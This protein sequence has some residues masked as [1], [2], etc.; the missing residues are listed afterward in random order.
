[1]YKS[2]PVLQA[3]EGTVDAA[4]GR[5][6]GKHSLLNQNYEIIKTKV[7]GNHRLA[8]VHEFNIQEGSNSVLIETPL[9]VPADLS[10]HGGGKG[11]Q[12]IVNNGFQGA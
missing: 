9:A 12:W 6:Y 3:F 4:H 10:Q 11:Q 2:E 1:M 8:S 7:A 5:M